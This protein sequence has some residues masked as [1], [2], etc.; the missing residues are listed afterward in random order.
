MRTLTLLLLLLLFIPGPGVAQEGEDV[1]PVALAALLISDGHWDRAAAVLAEVDAEDES[2]D[3]PRY[4]TLRGLIHLQAQEFTLAA[5]A[6]QEA[7]DAG[8]TDP[9]LRLHLA[10][11]WLGAEAPD[12]ALS[13][14]DAGGEASDA[15]PEAWLL[16]AQ[17]WRAKQDLPQAW[18]ALSAGAARFPERAAFDE[19]RVLLL[20]EMGLYQ[21]AKEMGQEVL[22]SRGA[23]ADT[24]IVMAEALNRSGQRFEAAV[25]LE[26]ARARFPANPDLPLQ[27]A[28]V[29]LE[30]GKPGAAGMILQVAA[31]H[32]AALYHQAAECY[33]RAGQVSA[34]LRMNALVP[35]AVE[36]TRQRLAILLEGGDFER[37][38]AL[39]PRLS[40]LG[41]LDDDNIRYGLGY[42][43]FQLIQYDE[44][45]R[46]LKGIRD[47]EI[48]RQAN[49]LRQAIEACRQSGACG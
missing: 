22:R 15:L 48:F 11:A 17:A 26:E 49:Q 1:D 40:R 2:V 8:A 20:V 25:L 13:A 29:Y 28:R 34:A 14:L 27:L 33:R 35:D 24:W 21:H 44:A 38:V 37:M 5:E 46:A 47:P 42:A 32:D 9:W 12:K 10:Q 4:H 31:E 30:D 6:L 43:H 7:I 39:E 36:K 23:S 3:W 16:R 18:V 45:E 19:Q 41:L